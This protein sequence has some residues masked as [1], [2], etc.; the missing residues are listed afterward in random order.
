MF[1]GKVWGGGYKDGFYEKLL[2][3]S[4]VSN[5]ANAAG[6]KMVPLLDK[7]ELTSDGGRTSGIM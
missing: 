4:T 2:E 7:T 6:C 3:A 5:G 1:D